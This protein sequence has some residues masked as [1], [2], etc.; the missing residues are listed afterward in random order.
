MSNDVQ[1]G[2]STDPQSQ[3]LVV[4]N[5]LTAS[6]WWS[7]ATPASCLA[8]DAKSGAFAVALPREP[9]RRW[10]TNQAHPQLPQLQG[11]AAM[12]V[13]GTQHGSV[14]QARSRH[15]SRS[16]DGIR[17]LL[18]ALQCEDSSLRRSQPLQ[19]SCQM[20][21]LL[22]QKQSRMAGLAPQETPS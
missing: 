16:G 6:V 9:V 12:D 2:T 1:V 4:W 11:D 22:T 17:V 8:V 21:A 3:C 15:T 19:D 10:V 5:L 20:V 18:G 7:A 13:T 14:Q